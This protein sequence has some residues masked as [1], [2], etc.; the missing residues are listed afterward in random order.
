MYAAEG[1]HE[2]IVQAL[3]AAGANVDLQDEVSTL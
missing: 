2:S 3:V 1:G